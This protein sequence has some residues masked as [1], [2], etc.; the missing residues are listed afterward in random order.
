MSTPI[1]EYFTKI[2]TAIPPTTHTQAYL[3]NIKR[4]N[5]TVVCNDISP[6]IAQSEVQS[7]INT[8]QNNT[9]TGLDGIPIKFYKALA[10]NIQNTSGNLQ[11]PIFEKTTSSQK[12]AIVKLIPKIPQP[13][14]P[15]QYRP[16]S[17]FNCD[18][19]I[20]V[21]IIS[22]RLC[23]FL[24]NYISPAQQCGMP[25]RKIDNIHQNILATIQHAHNYTP[26]GLFKSIRQ[27]LS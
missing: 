19:K 18:Y 20:L 26:T 3:Q 1:I 15:S 5:N 25:N 22:S 6:N 7:T 10:P 21:K 8:F 27:C 14:H 4:L 24:T 23:A 2:W 9:S 17:L 11:Q 12:R 16:I 13:K